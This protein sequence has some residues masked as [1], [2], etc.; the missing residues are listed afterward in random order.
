MLDAGHLAKLTAH[1]D[2]ERAEYNDEVAQSLVATLHDEHPLQLDAE[3]TE[4]LAVI[5]QTACDVRSFPAPV[6]DAR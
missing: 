1:S 6:H 4:Q 5:A 3:E 2:D